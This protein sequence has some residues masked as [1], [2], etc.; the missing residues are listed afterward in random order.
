MS[1]ALAGRSVL[2]AGAGPV[3]MTAAL[4]LARGGFAPRIVDKGDGPAPISES[5][6]LAVNTRSLELLAPSGASSEIVAQAQHITE[7]RVRSRRHPLVTIDLSA[8]PGRYR[9]VHGL[10]Q[11]RTERILMERLEGHGVGIEWRKEARP[12]APE[13]TLASADGSEEVV[14]PDLLI[15]ADGAHSGI[16]KALGIGFPGESVGSTFYLADIRYEQPLDTH[17][18]EV[19]F[20][21]PGVI[22]RLPVGGD[23]FRYIS[24][25][26]NFLDLIDHPARVAGMPWKTDFHVSFR[27]VDPMSKGNVFLAGDAAHIHSPVGG[28]GM[29]LGIEDACWLAWLISQGRERDYSR[30]R[31]GTARAVLKQTHMMTR[32]VLLRNRAATAAR[33]FLLPLAFRVPAVRHK[34]LRAIAGHDT[35]HPP[36]LAEDNTTGQDRI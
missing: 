12:G 36:W 11:G 7:M 2:I 4:E 31:V 13:V 26:E 33:G 28:R 3:G 14:R 29:N 1:Q 20:F 5:R 27:H 18:G 25:M 24:T 30:L 23:T 32:M 34:V 19:V 8:S 6:A 10:A 15:A 22:A 35:P 17:F 9:G 16:R 21:D